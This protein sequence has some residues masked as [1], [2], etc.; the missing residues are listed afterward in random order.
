[1]SPARPADTI[2]RGADALLDDVVVPPSAMIPALGRL[3]GWAVG[4]LPAGLTG[5]VGPE[6]SRQAGR[7]PLIDTRRTS[8]VR[9]GRAAHR[10]RDGNGPRPGMAPGSLVYR[11]GIRTILVGSVLAG[12]LGAT[13]YAVA[14]VS[15]WLVP[16]YLLLVVVILTAP[17]GPREASRAAGTTAVLRGPL[18]ERDGSPPPH[19]VPLPFGARA[20]AWFL[21]TGISIGARRLRVPSP[22]RG[23]GARRAGEG[24]DEPAIAGRPETRPDA[25]SDPAAPAVASDDAGPGT[26]RIDPA[27]NA[28]PKPRKSRARSR[29]TSKPAVEAAPDSAPVTWVRVGPGQFVRSDTINQ[30]QPPAEAPPPVEVP[31]PVEAL[32]PAEVPPPV[33]A[34]APAEVP[35]PVEALAPAEVPPPV[36]ASPLA[37]VPDVAMLGDP[38]TDHPQPATAEP[39]AL[40]EAGPAADV[41]EAD[42]PVSE[43]PATVAQPATDA[44]VA[45]VIQAAEDVATE[46][47]PTAD[48]PATEPSAP[49]VVPE[50]E[51][52]AEE[53][54]IAP[55]AFMVRGPL[56]V[57]RGSLSRRARATPRHRTP[58]DGR[59][60]RTVSRRRSRTDKRRPTRAI[61]RPT[62]RRGST[63]RRQRTT[64]EGHWT[65]RAR[66]PPPCS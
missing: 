30:G 11:R 16:V 1:M 23:E 58:H 65:H 28:I 20:I 13:A 21:R 46:A 63:I 62:S 22:H 60:P 54:G 57:V 37:E 66:S 14:S 2:T 25:A 4:A 17:R 42:A 41:S 19:P 24:P 32:A 12:L 31:P 48:Q 7:P 61:R 36:E 40:I 6:S 9:F 29:K 27:A 51:P 56:S 47:I 49:E 15:T 10:R 34:L 59:W 45:E 52:A 18:A 5:G 3:A 39:A 43:E 38:V 50:A 8:G 35:P 53:Y 64:D 33:E 44:P 26:L 55:S